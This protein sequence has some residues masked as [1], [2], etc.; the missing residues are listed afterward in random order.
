MIQLTRIVLLGSLAVF[1]MAPEAQAQWRK[2]DYQYFVDIDGG[3][4]SGS[5]DYANQTT[6]SLYGEDGSVE[7]NYKIDRS[8][9]LFNFSAGL[10]V[11]NNVGFAVGYSRSAAT[12]SVEVDVSTP[13]P[14]FYNQP[15]SNIESLDL[16][17]STSMAHFMAVYKLPLSSKMELTVTGGPTRLSVKQ[18]VVMNVDRTEGVWPYT[19]LADVALATE[20]ISKIGVG[21]N[22]GADLTYMLY[23][24]YGAG[25]FVRYAGGKID[26]P[27]MDGLGG[28]DVGG[29]Q[30]GGGLRWRW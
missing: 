27:V 17:R 2:L 24:N 23:R 11:W 28:F 4:Q 25:V 12:P 10:L 9:G 13:H 20:P 19:T 29:L 15:R 8:G 5:S 14:L 7:S 30:V 3:Y 26:F 16:S 6:F 21:F 22:V 1:W 18:P